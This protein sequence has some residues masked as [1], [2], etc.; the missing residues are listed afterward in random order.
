MNRLQQIPEL[1]YQKKDSPKLALKTRPETESDVLRVSLAKFL[2]WVDDIFFFQNVMSWKPK[3]NCMK[4]REL[5]D[6]SLFFKLI[7]KRSKISTCRYQSDWARWRNKFFFYINFLIH[8][9][10]T[11]VNCII[12][13][14]LIFVEHL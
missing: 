10:I 1:W 12:F 9:S 2:N 3:L 11:E 5:F 14:F 7:T 13:H 8:I 4:V 6:Q